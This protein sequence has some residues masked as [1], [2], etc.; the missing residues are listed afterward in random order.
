MILKRET[1]QLENINRFNAFN[2]T[3]F[4]LISFVK[5]SSFFLNK[6][7]VFIRV[8][9][10]GLSRLITFLNANS[11]SYRKCLLLAV[12]TIS[13][14]EV[15]PFLSKLILCEEVRSFKQHHSSNV[16]SCAVE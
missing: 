14:V 7:K 4:F 2:L 1:F 5:G 16:K 11:G 10:P 8:R 6:K 13:P 12:K 9:N 3:R 15:F